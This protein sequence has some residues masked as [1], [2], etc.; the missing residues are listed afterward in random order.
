MSSGADSVHRRIGGQILLAGCIAVKLPSWQDMMIMASPQPIQYRI[1]LKPKAGRLS[2]VESLQE[3]FA[4][5]ARNHQ[6]ILDYRSFV[7]SASGRVVYLEAFQ[8]SQAFMNYYND[9]NIQP[10]IEEVTKLGTIEEFEVY[11]D[12][13]AEVREFMDEYNAVYLKDSVGFSRV[14]APQATH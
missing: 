12:V 10:L 5:I 9:P 2:A 8:D 13:P 1:S 11:G 7:D 3:R 14:L 4:K 6:G